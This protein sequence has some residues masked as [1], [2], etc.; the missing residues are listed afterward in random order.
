MH[1]IEPYYKWRNHYI[2]SEDL[3]SPFFGTIYSEFEFT[4][5]IYNYLIHP[6]WDHFGSETLYLK[7]LYT[8]Y[9][10][11]FVIIELIGEW[12]DT[13]YND[14]MYLKRELIDLLT[15][16]GISKF[17]L[18]GE[19]VLNFHSSDD[20]YYEEWF[21]DIED[22]WILAINFQ[23][24]VIQEFIDQN[25]DYYIVFFEEFNNF[26]WRIYSPLKLFELL[27]QKVLRRLEI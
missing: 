4:N 14:V 6:Q 25:I 9:D 8:N 18:I 16:Q 22:G 5:K 26:N 15:K 11:G 24:H 3:R 19:N 1:T 2:A 17:I 20:S 7:V 13:L 12:N 27:E 23:E 21:D 10:L